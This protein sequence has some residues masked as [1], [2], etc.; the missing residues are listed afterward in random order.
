[1]VFPKTA[2]FL[3]KAGRNWRKA[4][5]QSFPRFWTRISET[6]KLEGTVGKCTEPISTTRHRV[7][8]T[9]RVAG[10]EGESQRAVVR[11]TQLG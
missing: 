11:L 10:R 1:M 8:K 9:S 2:E 7:F 4:K 6:V 5:G 3:H